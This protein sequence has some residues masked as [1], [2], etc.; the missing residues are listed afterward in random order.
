MS[1]SGYTDDCDEQWQY[2]LWRGTVASSLRSKRGQAF[3]KEMLAALDAMPVKRLIARELEGT[4]HVSFSHWGMIETDAVCAIGSVGRARGM[5]MS[6]IDP[7]DP[8][9]VSGKF[10]IGRPMACEIVYL[11][12]EWY[13]RETPEARFTRM[14]EWVVSQIKPEVSLTSGV[15]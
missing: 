15:L 10:N 4:D 11:N 3:L 1:R 13:R 12:D 5:D 8:E 9:T 14:R 2:A 6:S 7:D